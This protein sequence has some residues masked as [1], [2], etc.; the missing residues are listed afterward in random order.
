MR[1]REEIEKDISKFS[2]ECDHMVNSLETEQQKQKFADLGG[3]EALT[4]TV[5]AY[6]GGMVC[7]LLLDLREELDSIRMMIGEYILGQGK[8]HVK[9]LEY[10]ATNDKIIASLLQQ[11]LAELTK[12]K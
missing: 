10:Q 6:V 7:E 12:G 9:E 4:G 5:A 2:K 3:L 8:V 1:S 11:I